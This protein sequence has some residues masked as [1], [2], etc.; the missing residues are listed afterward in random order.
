MKITLKDEAISKEDENKDI[1]VVNILKE[2]DTYFKVT[3]VAKDV[4]SKISE[5]TEYKEIIN[6]IMDKYD[7]SEEQVKKDVDQFIDDLKKFDLIT[8]EDE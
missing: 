6:N 5:G 2:D 7:A 8:T 1:V 4:F 3:G